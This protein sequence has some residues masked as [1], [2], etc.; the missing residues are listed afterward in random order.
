M[1]ITFFIGEFNGGGAERVISI[2]A[3]Y[4]VDRGFDVEILKYHNTENVYFTDERV[5]IDSVEEHTNSR[6]SLIKNILWLRKY[7]KKDTDIVVSFLAPFNII[8]IIANMFN[9]TPI[10]VADRNDPS[11]TPTN[12]FI[13]FVR[14]VL[15][16]FADGIVLQTKKNK[17][18][19]SKGIQNKSVII[20]NPIDIGDNLGLALKSDKEQVIV[21]VARLE[22][23]KNQKILIN[24]FKNIADEFKEYKLCIYGEGSYR[25]ELEAYINELGLIGRILLPGNITDVINKIASARM[26][27]LSSDYEGMSNALI[28][29]MCIGLPVISTKVSGS[30][31]LIR[32]NENGLLVDVNDEEAL[33]KAIRSL[34]NSNVLCERFGEQATKITSLLNNDIICDKWLKYIMSFYK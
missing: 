27:V 23:Q 28:E 18:Y 24:A 21:S 20:Y 8:A 7:F 33:T 13:R 34:L 10:I 15:Y 14:N 2:L 9:T 16:R 1:K 31:D 3:N 5:V 12:V 11:Y 25:S 30:E 19:F 17:D 4:I 6:N 32:H 26:F 29:A 22:K